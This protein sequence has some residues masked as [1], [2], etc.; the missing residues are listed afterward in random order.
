MV[1]SGID[2]IWSYLTSLPNFQTQGVSGFNPGLSNIKSFCEKIGNPQLAFPTIHV[3]GTN[4]KGTVSSM[5]SS[6]LQQE[7][8][9][10]GLYTS[11]HLLT[12]HE[13]FKINGLECSDEDLIHFFS[14][15]EELILISSLTYFELLTAFC[16]WHFAKNKVEIAVIEVGL[17]GR[18]DA[19]NIIIPLVS[20]ITSIGFDHKDILG[21]TYS[22]IANE[23]AG[24]IKSHIPIVIGDLPE[25]AFV[26]IQDR[27]KQNY[28]PFHSI[29]SITYKS[30]A[31]NQFTSELYPN[32]IFDL[33]FQGEINIKNALL[34][35]LALKQIKNN[36][37]IKIQALQNGLASVRLNSGLKGRFERIHPNYKWYFDGAHNEEA[38]F[39]LKQALKYLYKPKD[40]II[41]CTFMADKDYPLLLK[42]YSE[43]REIFF[44]ELNH[45]RAAK[46]EQIKAID[47]HCKQLDDVNFA[48]E[49]A[50]FKDDVVIFT[51]SFY[52]YQLVDSWIRQI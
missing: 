26:L 23:K 28:S 50:N 48:K 5:L 9:K 41:V 35:Q 34:V 38:F 32:E 11:P 36:F 12:V 51:G 14:T 15:F 37:P 52:F 49:L 42:H 4:G 8:Y 3:A 39:W 27:A 43:F 7:G 29:S 21:N 24:I 16:F 40:C 10:T 1:F 18:L 20:I 25:E 45:P 6:V 19:T 33:D 31:N 30:N 46:F 2:A 13:R 22:E 47:P 17:G 44:F